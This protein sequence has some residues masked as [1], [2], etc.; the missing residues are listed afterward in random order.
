VQKSENVKER[1]IIYLSKNFEVKRG[2]LANIITEG[3]VDISYVHGLTVSRFNS[4]NLSWQNDYLTIALPNLVLEKSKYSYKHAL[5]KY[6]PRK[7]FKVLQIFYRIITKKLILSNIKSEAA[8]SGL[9]EN[10]IVQYHVESQFI[11]ENY[12]TLYCDCLEF[13][14]DLSN[15]KMPS[16]AELLID[17]RKSPTNVIFNSEIIFHLKKLVEKAEGSNNFKLISEEKV[18]KQLSSEIGINAGEKFIYVEAPEITFPLDVVVLTLEQNCE[19]FLIQNL[20]NN[21]IKGEKIYIDV[22]LLSRLNN[23][24]LNSFSGV[25]WIRSLNEINLGDM[26]FGKIYT[27]KPSAL[28]SEIKAFKF[29]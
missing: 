13:I 14:S 8:N 22:D 23:L 1:Q 12:S 24:N 29:K 11:I 10:E 20:T 15:L 26:T 6:L 5:R 7:L 2:E 4:K 28:F 17:L 9:A 21:H 3:K 27:C 25:H 19:E 18:A 16:R